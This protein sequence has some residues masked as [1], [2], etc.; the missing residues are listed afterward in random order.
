[1]RPSTRA[2]PRGRE[3]LTA[4]GEAA[5]LGRGPVLLLQAAFH[6]DADVAQRAWDTLVADAGGASEVMV[7]AC[8]G[9]EQRLLPALG[10]RAELLELPAEVSRTCRDLTV[11][12]WGL[13]ERL[14][15]VVRPAI[16]RLLDAGVPLAALK[17]VALIGDAYPQHRLRPIG[18]VDLLVPRSQV[19]RALRVL[20]NEGW[21]DPESDR[22]MRRV[23]RHAVNL[24][25]AHGGASIDLH[26]RPLVATPHR[27]WR[28]PWPHRELEPLPAEHPLADTG[29]QRPTAARLLVLVT[30]H[31]LEWNNPSSHWLAD[32]TQLLLAHP[33]L[34]GHEVARVA[35]QD[36]LSLQVREGL[37]M[38]RDLLGAPVPFPL[39]LLDPP[40][41][42][43]ERDER[44]RWEAR[45]QARAL[46]DRP[47]LLAALRRFVHYGRAGT[48]RRFWT[49]RLHVALAAAVTWV[50]LRRTGQR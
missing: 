48:L 10:R 3:P 31:G 30:A 13:N 9:A 20:A 17:G 41:P 47:G 35:A 49:S 32:V 28:Q 14:L 12:S 36:R 16:E 44:G 38:A 34:D 40:S 25:G 4:L 18:D 42:A 23:A 21:S 8:R 24:G 1:M 26:W 50:Y 27:I 22:P 33:D 15:I 29:L 19:S 6:Q 39:R 2:K 5:S 45:A 7:W 43:A 11:E 46:T 37:R